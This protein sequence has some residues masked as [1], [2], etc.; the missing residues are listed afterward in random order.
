[1]PNLAEEPD[2]WLNVDAEDFDA[3]LAETIRS[4]PSNTE[5]DVNAMDVDIVDGEDAAA[6][7]QAEKLKGL[8]KKIENFVEGEGTLE[9]AVLDECVLRNKLR[10]RR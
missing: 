9:G 6:E 2:D 4:R 1:M 10:R 7:S 5:G 3:K 8:A